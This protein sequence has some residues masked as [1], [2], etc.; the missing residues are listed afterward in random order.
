[1]RALDLGCGRAT[2]SIF[3]A[4]E[5]R[6]TVWAADLWIKPTDNHL[7]IAQSGTSAQVFLLS[8]EAHELPFADGYFDA[9][10]SIDACHDFGTGDLYLGTISNFVRPGGQLGIVVLGLLRKQEQIPPHLTHTGIGSLQAFTRRRG[11]GS[12]GKK[13]VSWFWIS[14]IPCRTA[15]NAGSSGASF[16]SSM[17]RTICG[18]RW[19]AKPKCYVSTTGALWL[20]RG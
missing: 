13:P 8:V 14:T 20:R 5:F 9:I 2:S 3:L 10:V 11:G 19:D 16:V 6:V 15:G 7:L 17:V 12:T 18:E 4:K 1:M